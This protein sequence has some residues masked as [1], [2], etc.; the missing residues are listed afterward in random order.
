M[1]ERWAA[2]AWLLAEK[3]FR[4]IDGHQQ[5]WTLAAIPRREGS[6]TKRRK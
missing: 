2:S 6:S 5:L 3:N 1:V 4:R